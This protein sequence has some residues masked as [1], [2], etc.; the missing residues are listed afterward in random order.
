MPRTVT[1]WPHKGPCFRLH[2]G[3]ENVDD[4]IAD[5]DHAFQTIRSL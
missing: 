4:L 1:P 2:A 3:L 5:L